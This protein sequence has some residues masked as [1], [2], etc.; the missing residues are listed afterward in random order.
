MPHFAWKTMA[1]WQ[2]NSPQWERQHIFFPLERKENSFFPNKN[3]TKP[4]TS[5]KSYPNPVKPVPHHNPT[6]L[7]KP[8][9]N[10]F[11]S[12]TN[13]CFLT[14]LPLSLNQAET[15]G[16]W[17]SERLWHHDG[18]LFKGTLLCITWGLIRTQFIK[19]LHE[20][21]LA[22]HTGRNK[23]IALIDDRFYWPHLKRD[24]SYVV[25]PCEVCQNS[26]FYTLYLFLTKFG[27]TFPWIS[28]WD[29]LTLNACV[30]SS[31]WLHTDF[32]K[33]TISYLARRQLM[34][35]T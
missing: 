31:L 7:T 5:T 10:S 33:W 32:L 4:K 15:N 27:N 9:E 3:P 11:F 2:L 19:D 18:F 25:Q 34:Q 28:Y 30:T 12:P 23:T 22:A 21:G 1:I 16:A 29:C 26:R 20:W 24:V 17:T 35:L 14:P 6:P 8:I 13:R